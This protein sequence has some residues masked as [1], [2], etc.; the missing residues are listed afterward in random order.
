MK[1]HLIKLQEKMVKCIDDQ[2]PAQIA[3]LKVE[4]ASTSKVVKR[5][6][7]HM[8]QQQVMKPWVAQ[9]RRDM[10]P[11]THCTLMM[12]YVSMYALS[13]RKFSCLVILLFYFG[14][15]G[16]ID[17]SVD[18]HLIFSCHST[19]AAITRFGLQQ[20]FDVAHIQD[21]FR[22]Y[23]TSLIFRIVSGIFCNQETMDQISHV[24]N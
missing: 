15:V 13:G 6:E 5:Y 14:E 11:L 24:T 1:S 10:V 23:L 8:K 22:C 20:L 12:D 2:K 3:A 9:K 4:V 17:A 16:A 21:R 7:Q 18:I 19:T